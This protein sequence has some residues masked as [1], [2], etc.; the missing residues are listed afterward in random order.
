MAA[1]LRHRGPDD[2][3]VWLGE[4]VGFAHRRLAVIDPSL[5]GHQPMSRGDG[6][7]TITFNGEI[8]NY[9]ELR[10]ELEAEGERFHTGSDTEVLLAALIR[11]NRG[12]LERL[13]GMFAFAFW[14][15]ADRRL[16]V[17]RDRIGEKPFYYACVGGDFVFG[18]EIKALLAWPGLERRADLEAIHHYLSLQYVPSPL[19]AFQGVS[20][21]PPGCFIEMSP[22]EAPTPARYW[23]L[24]RPGTIEP[25][26]DA[27]PAQLADEARALLGTAVRRQLVADVP[28]GA[29]LSGGV[30]S[31][32]VT[33]LMAL[34]AGTS[35]KTFT[36]GF[37]HSAYDERR[38]A[39]LVA[40]RYGTEHH[41]E[42]VDAKASE[43]LPELVWHYGEPFA[44]PS[45]IP[46]F[47]V[48]R[49]A[50]RH[51]TVAL[52]GDG[53]DEFFLG[54][55][56]Y[57]DCRALSWVDQVPT[58]LRRAAAWAA[59]AMPD[60]LAQ[61]RYFR[62]ARRLL[63]LAALS[64]SD[65]Y[66]PAMMYFQ[67]TDKREGYGDALRP[68]LG[69]S[70]PDLLDPY[71]AAA[72]D[73]VS[74]AAWADIHTYLPDD[75]LVKVDVASMAVGLEC[76]APFLDVDLMEWAA[77]VPASAKLVDG[78]LKGL[79]K[80][81]VARLLPTEIVRRPKMGFGAPID[82]WLRHEFLAMAQEVLLDPRAEARG[83]FRPGYAQRLLSEHRAGYRHHHPRLWAM[84]ML[85][86]WFRVWIDP[87]AA[88][89][90][91]PIGAISA[92]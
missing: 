38:F 73:M 24:P 59:G 91:R 4:G 88:P 30:D 42:V 72:P 26:S 23:N 63:Q 56:R 57:A 13:N 60:G 82:I 44:D 9:R 61:R 49:L 90:E 1:L 75:L 54:Y 5:R 46:T 80:D 31:S 62:G 3:G 39:R 85:E 64:P 19:T 65:R 84:I 29:F 17:A 6:R 58:P 48:S 45:A 74:G 11:W 22:G 15:A 83:L 92:P 25:R 2:E 41:V 16:M 69:E 36:I 27:S 28:V 7:W 71:F 32:S 79:L 40:E 43:I 51:V 14:D 76:R 53:G 52:T 67:G 70:S 12:A 10:G 77:G 86:L 33:A 78:A 47:L 81:A 87:A 37:D 89:V 21:L 34:E 50:R 8:Y 66:E 55:G 20:K 68:Y 18:S 35:V